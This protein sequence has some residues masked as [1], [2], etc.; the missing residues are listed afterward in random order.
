MY[1]RMEYEEIVRTSK[2]AIILFAFFEHDIYAS[3]V[4]ELLWDVIN[5]LDFQDSERIAF[6]K[7]ELEGVSVEH[8][9][10]DLGLDAT[11]GIV[12]FSN[13][14]PRE[15]FYFPFSKDDVA[16]VVFRLMLE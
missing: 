15:R 5:E 11:P 3:P 1:T 14:T 6:G 16:A 2:Y 7:V 13:G 9:F 8:V 12:A 10:D 4:D